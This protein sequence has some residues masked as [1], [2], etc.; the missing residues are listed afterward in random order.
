MDDQAKRGSISS[1]A[2]KQ[3]LQAEAFR[4]GFT[5]FGVTTPSPSQHIEKYLQWLAEG[6]HGSMAYL[7]AENA[8]TK[9]ANPQW[10]MPEAQSIIVLGTPYPAFRHK[11]LPGEMEYGLVAAYV[12][13]QDYHLVIPPKIIN[14]VHFLEERINQ[15]IQYKIYTDTGPILE[16]EL[17]Q[18]AGLG[19]IGKNTCLISPGQGS[20]F[21]LAEVFLDVLIDPNQPFTADRCGKCE[22]CIQACPT[23]CILSNRTIDA[24]KCIS[25]LT[26]ENKGEISP[27]LREKIGQWAFGCDICQQVCPWNQ[28]RID[29]LQETFSPS[30]SSRYYVNIAKEITIHPSEFKDKFKIS[31][32]LRAKYRG[33]VR[34]LA[35]IAGNTKNE[36]FIIHLANLLSGSNEPLV[37]AHAAW[38]LGQIGSVKALQFLSTALHHEPESLVLQEISRAIEVLQNQGSHTGRAAS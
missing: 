18:K 10:I 30:D 6:N 17:A 11:T 2:L 36:S 32:I 4:L 28:K 7:A 20:M 9:R 13:D 33:Y 29:S 15:T 27:A 5:L 19:W 3:E 38:A 23:Q 31:P 37:R 22:R 14:L 12:Q 26:I 8:L 1:A 34:N 35:V 21:L 24:R 25:Y 16:R